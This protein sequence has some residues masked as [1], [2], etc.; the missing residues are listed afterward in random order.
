MAANV[1]R[2]CAVAAIYKKYYKKDRRG[3]SRVFSK[4]DKLA[5]A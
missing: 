2:L 5:M 1:P 3:V 4:K